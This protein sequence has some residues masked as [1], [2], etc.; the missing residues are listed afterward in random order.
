MIDIMEVTEGQANKC[1]YPVQ[2]WPEQISGVTDSVPEQ[3]RPDQTVT[4]ND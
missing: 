4:K 3:W 2:F 1:E